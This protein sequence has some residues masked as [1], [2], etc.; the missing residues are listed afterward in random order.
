MRFDLPSTP[1]GQADLR[2]RMTDAIVR[3]GRTADGVVPALQREGFTGAEIAAGI[4]A[5]RNA[6]RIILRE[7]AS[8]TG[9]SIARALALTLAAYPELTGGRA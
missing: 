7:P 4:D 1:D 9:R 3:H 8:A 6:A 5:A 2:R